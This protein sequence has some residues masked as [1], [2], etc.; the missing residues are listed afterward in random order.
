M[1]SFHSFSFCDQYLNL[2]IFYSCLPKIASS[3]IYV[4]HHLRPILTMYD[5]LSSLHLLRYHALLQQTTDL[6]TSHRKCRKRK[7]VCVFVTSYRLE[8]F[9]MKMLLHCDRMYHHLIL[10][11]MILRSEFHFGYA[12]LHFYGIKNCSHANHADREKMADYNCNQCHGF[13]DMWYYCHGK[14]YPHANH[15]QGKM[16]DYRS[17]QEVTCRGFEEC[18]V[19]ASFC[20][21]VDKQHSS[22]L[23]FRRGMLD[24]T[25]LWTA[26]FSAVYALLRK[27]SVVLEIQGLSFKSIFNLKWNLE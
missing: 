8:N 6:M 13:G 27:P 10:P 1:L 21:F 18:Y 26:L 17:N 5:A 14:M 23:D 19:E 9:S 22:A 7:I 11:H 20:A 25:V 2:M 16:A 12:I 15:F 3:L 24:S 4:C